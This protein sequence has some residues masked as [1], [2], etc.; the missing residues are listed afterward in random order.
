MSILSRIAK[1]FGRKDSYSLATFLWGSGSSSW[2][3]IS[4]ERLIKEGFESNVTVYACVMEIAR[5]CAGIP[6]YLCKESGAQEDRV[7]EH[8]ILA[9]LRRPNPLQGGQQFFEAFVA[10][11]EIAGNSYIYRT[12]GKPELY[13]LKPQSVVVL[14]SGV[15]GT[16]PNGYRYTDAIGKTSQLN[17]EQVLHLKIFSASDDCYGM[18]PLQAAA[19]VVD[20]DNQ[21]QLWNYSLLNNQARPA[22][23]MTAKL[24]LTDQQRQSLKAEIQQLWSGGSNAG[25][26]ILLE[27][28]LTWTPMGSTAIEMDWLNGKKLSKREICQAFQVPPE[29]IGDAEAKTYSNYQEARKS[30]YTE[31]I[32]PLMDGI[33]DQLNL[34]FEPE[35]GGLRLEYDLDS[36]E[37]LQEDRKLTWDRVS[38]A[39]WLSINEQRLATG[40]EEIPDEESD[41][42]RA[43]A[44]ARALSSLS[45][46]PPDPEEEEEPEEEQAP[47][48][49][50]RV[51]FSSKFFDLKTEEQKAAFWADNDR[52]RRVFEATA[53]KAF[54][55]HFRREKRQIVAALGDR[56]SSEPAAVDNALRVV[57]DNQ[58]RLES[59]YKTVFLQVGRFFFNEVVK[60][61]GKSRKDVG[62]SLQQMRA[63]ISVT[64]DRRSKLVTQTTEDRLAKLLKD[65]IFGGKSDEEIVDAVEVFYDEQQVTT[66]ADRLAETEVGA[67]SGMGATHGAQAT[68][69]ALMKVW[70]SQRD[71]K[72]RDHHKEADSKKVG[73]DDLFIVNGQQMEFPGDDSHGATPDNTVNCRCFMAFEEAV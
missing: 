53:R 65:A 4:T 10:F 36:I 72:V 30:F 25:R 17:P 61:A 73:L 41:I 33:K 43:L 24:G 37:A 39:D 40:Y 9:L 45:A 52:K 54:Q 22:G 32:L 7:E 11:L 8:K 50:K 23:A 64:A 58:Q 35:L 3:T 38:S 6:W 56:P 67:A 28:G 63:K 26:P 51:S 14:K 5:S 59:V 71:D 46:P 18:S 21:A 2:P 49:D 12:L 20:T 27:E 55:S 13:V 42:P 15:L 29:L 48:D 16:P 62:M 60:A 34:W 19:R 31:T 47:D 1:F 66:R 57:R 44:S 68:E 69:K 70:I